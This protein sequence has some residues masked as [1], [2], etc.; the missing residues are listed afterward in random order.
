MHKKKINLHGYK[1]F[2]IQ[3]YYSLIYLN[4]ILLFCLILPS[5]FTKIISYEEV[6]QVLGIHGRKKIHISLN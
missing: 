6:R 5:C 2:E 3:G 4:D 1:H